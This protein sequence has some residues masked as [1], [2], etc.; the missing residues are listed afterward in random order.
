LAKGACI[1][2]GFVN[3]KEPVSVYDAGLTE[4]GIKKEIDWLFE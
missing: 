2:L 3:G 4:Q 1:V